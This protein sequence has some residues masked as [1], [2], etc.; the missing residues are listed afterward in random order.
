MTKT[1]KPM[2]YGVFKVEKADNPYGLT[3]VFQYPDKKAIGLKLKP[4]IGKTVNM[5]IQEKKK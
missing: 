4:F 5:F 1:K 2:Q 3:F